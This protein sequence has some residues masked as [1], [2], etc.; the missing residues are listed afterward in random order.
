MA[1]TNR[2]LRDIPALVEI[3]RDQKARTS[4]VVAPRGKLEF[5]NDTV[6]VD[7]RTTTELVLRVVSKDYEPKT[8]RIQPQVHGQFASRFEIPK[9][10][11]DRMN[12]EAR[13]LLVENL[14]VWR[15]HSAKE[16]NLVRLIDDQVRGFVGS[17]Y[18]PISHLDLVTTAVQVIT[19]A[20]AG[21]KEAEPWGLGARCFDWGISPTNLRIG[22]VNPCLQVD[23]NNLDRGVVQVPEAEAMKVFN[24]G[25]DHSFRKAGGGDIEHPMFPCAFIKNSETGH[26][27][28]N[29]QGGLYESVCDNTCAVGTDFVRRHIGRDLEE[30]DFYTSKTYEKLNTAIY[31][32][33]ADCIRNVFDPELLLSNAR[34]MKGLEEEEADIKTAVDSI[35]KLP[36]MTEDLRD[37]ILSSYQPLKQG[38]KT[39]LDVQRA[40]TA[41]AHGR[42]EAEPEK[43]EALEALG[44]AIVER[45]AA[46]LVPAK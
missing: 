33:V 30:G 5:L 41:A 40:V 37:D 16:K 28:L 2:V 14:E 26:G 4:D 8:Y 21:S 17:R 18:R 42:R 34:K 25:G 11:Y 35:V 20:D 10:Y 7:D 38:K 45:G 46:A 44:G 1:R 15:K 22:F 32:K 12:A 27:G 6:R 43:A 19:G 13:N 31:A 24:E 39:L 3:L 36:G 29:V 23:L 9:K